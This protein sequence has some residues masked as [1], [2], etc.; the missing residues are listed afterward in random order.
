MGMK[1]TFGFEIDNILGN[2]INEE[3]AKIFANFVEASLNKILEYC[4]SNTAYRCLGTDECYY[5]S[6]ICFV[7]KELETRKRIRAKNDF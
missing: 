6:I 2:V 3:K 5:C 4:Y 7:R 1:L